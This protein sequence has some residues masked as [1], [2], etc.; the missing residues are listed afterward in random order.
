MFKKKNILTILFILFSF[1][2]Y[3]VAENKIV[4]VDLDYIL[5]NTLVDK[6]LFDNL[7]KNENLKFEELNIE[8]QNLKNKENE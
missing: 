3:S 4:Y 7:K 1:Q 6:K 8:E 2:N 5:S